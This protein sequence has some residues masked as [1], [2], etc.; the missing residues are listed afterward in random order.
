MH[1]FIFRS[2]KLAQLLERFYK[3]LES[4]EIKHLTRFHEKRNLVLPAVH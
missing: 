1:E 4:F 3:L 2:N